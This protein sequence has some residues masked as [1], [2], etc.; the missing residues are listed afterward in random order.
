MTVKANVL[1]YST[2]FHTAGILMACG[3]VTALFVREI[4]REGKPDPEHTMVEM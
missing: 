2:V 4:K 1:A 3:A